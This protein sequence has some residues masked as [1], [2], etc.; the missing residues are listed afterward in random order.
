M[1]DSV[2]IYLLGT[3]GCG[4]STMAAAM[5]GW[6]EEAGISFQ[7]VNLDPG[8]DLIP[9]EPDVDV[10]DWMTL[11]DIMEEYELGPNGGQIVAADMLALYSSRI[12]SELD[13]K[14][15]KYIIF[16]TPG[17]F[18]LFTFREATRE[19]VSTLVPNSFLVYLVDPFNSRTPS[20]FIS[21]LML[22]SLA[23]MRFLTPS[24]E[25]LSKADIVESKMMEDIKRWQDNPEQLQDDIMEGARERPTMANELSLGIV[26]TIEEMGIIPKL[27][28]VSSATKEGIRGIYE[29][30]QLTFGGGEDMEAQ[31][32]EE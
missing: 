17:Q 23:R 14:G 3:A 19:L 18:E 25:V 12:R 20:G 1:Q 27:F 13:L 31:D 28:P 26:R 10:R 11:A 24:V 5:A 4:K 21:Q 22:S 16:D 2:G 32:E 15:G 30:V 6:L 7:L 9:Y 29:R 8:A